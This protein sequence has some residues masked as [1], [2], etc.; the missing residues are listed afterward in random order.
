MSLAACRKI[1][2]S[3]GISRPPSERKELA[4]SVSSCQRFAAALAPIGST[5][6]TASA[7]AATSAIRAARVLA[8][9]V[10]VPWGDACVAGGRR[11]RVDR[12]GRRL[13]VALCG[14]CAEDHLLE[15]LGEAACLGV[16][17]APLQSDGRLSAETRA[18]VRAA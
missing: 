5:I 11:R 9:A 8:T 14:H 13:G 18:G 16:L 2:K 12:R 3:Y 4:Q 10:T 7:Q 1:A 15:R 17:D 6:A